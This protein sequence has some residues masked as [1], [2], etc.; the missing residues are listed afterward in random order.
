MKLFVNVMVAAALTLSFSINAYGS[1]QN[2]TQSDVTIYGTWRWNKSAP[3][4]AYEIT[5]SDNGN[6]RLVRL[7][8]FDVAPEYE[9]KF[10]KLPQGENEYSFELSM[11]YGGDRPPVK[12]HFTARIDHGTI[13][14]FN[15]A[16]TLEEINFEG[17]DMV[18]FK[19]E[20]GTYPLAISSDNPTVLDIFKAL[21]PFTFDEKISDAY[22]FIVNGTSSND[23]N[24]TEID[25]KIVD[26]A[27]GY[28]YY[29]TSGVSPFDDSFEWPSALECRCWKCDDGNV[30]FAMNRMREPVDLW[31]SEVEFYRYD[32]KNKMVTTIDAPFSLRIEEDDYWHF[33]LPQK[34]NDI[35]VICYDDNLAKKSSV[36]LRW[37]GNEFE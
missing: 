11:L 10:S 26:L 31:L 30:L 19:E 13:L 22:R 15:T 3:N 23:F 12:G 25:K 4:E 21:Y 2:S 16:A 18:F 5:F 37:N 36:L 27:N 28:M 9:G 17:S 1:Q 14:H 8:S 29:S 34:G 35:E 20:G 32:V 7:N 6:M 33:A 24:D